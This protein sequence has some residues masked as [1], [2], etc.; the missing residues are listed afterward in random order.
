[1][2]GGKVRVLGSDGLN[3]ADLR[4]FLPQSVTKGGSDGEDELTTVSA[5]DA[6]NHT[7]RYGH[8]APTGPDSLPMFP[9]SE[10]DP[11]I[12]NKRPAVYFSGNCDKFESLLVGA[13]GE[14]IDSATSGKDVS[15]LICIP[16]FALTGEVVLVNLKTLECEVMSFDDVG[17]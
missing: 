2:V 13:N 11:F 8:I 9:S 5:I 3:V 1:V 16:S 12:L 7:F 6:L 14:E 15:R 4:R 17:L 10:S